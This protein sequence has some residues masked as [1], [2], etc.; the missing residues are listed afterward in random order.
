MNFLYWQSEQ[1]QVL[2][3]LKAGGFLKD[4]NG[5][6]VIP[7]LNLKP[8][9]KLANEVNG[10]LTLLSPDDRDVNQ[11][12]GAETSEIYTEDEQ[13]RTS[14]K[15]NEEGP[16]LLLIVLPLT[17]LF[18]RGILFSIGLI[19]LPSFFALPDSVMALA[20]MICGCVL[21]SRRQFV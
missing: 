6:I 20:G 11:I 2:D 8:L 7:K 9:R 10:V 12:I 19:F 1:K 16:W 15:W 4:R 3:C 14:D 18:R 5:A 13:Q 21:I 17:A